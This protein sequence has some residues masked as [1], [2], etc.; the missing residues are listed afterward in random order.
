VNYCNIGPV[1]A[2]D[3]VKIGLFT[4][5]QTANRRLL[6]LEDMGLIVRVN[7]RLHEEDGGKKRR[8]SFYCNRPF[9]VKMLRHER[10]AMQVFLSWFP[11]ANAVAGKAVD[12]T[13]RA[14]MEV[15]IGRNLT[16]IGGRDGKRF[17]LEND[18]GNES[19]PFVKKRLAGYESCPYA[20]LFVAQ[21]QARINDVMCLTRNPLIYF[22]TFER[23]ITDPWGAHWVNCLG[24]RVAAPKPDDKAAALGADKGAAG[25]VS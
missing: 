1:E 8:K 3:L 13:W 23:A 16:W 12:Q 5:R 20:V 6:K 11:H 24:E 17:E 9:W 2:N 14:D 22:T 7:G 10:H 25:G 15:W 18:E 19:L 21:T 4:R